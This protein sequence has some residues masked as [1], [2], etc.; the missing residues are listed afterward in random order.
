[1][2]CFKHVDIAGPFARRPANDTCGGVNTEAGRQWARGDR[3]ACGCAQR[4]KLTRRL[5]DAARRYREID[6]YRAQLVEIGGELARFSRG[7]S[8]ARDVN[9]D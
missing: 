5:R 1:M 6:L 7:F 2:S 3:A 9:L 4:V 8:K